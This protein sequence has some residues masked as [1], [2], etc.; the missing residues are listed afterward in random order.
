MQ[1]QELK[2]I[3]ETNKDKLRDVLPQMVQDAA[4]DRFTGQAARSPAEVGDPDQ[5]FCASPIYNVIRVQ[6]LIDELNREIDDRVAG[7]M[8]GLDSQVSSKKAA[9]DALTAVG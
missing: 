4:L 1:L 3:Q 7:I 6:S 8:A 9:L 2:T 5:R